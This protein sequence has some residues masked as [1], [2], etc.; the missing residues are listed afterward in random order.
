LAGERLYGS[1]VLGSADSIVI[2]GRS[3]ISSQAAGDNVGLVRVTPRDN[4]LIDNGYISTSTVDIGRAGDISVDAGRLTLINGGQIA[5]SSL[6]SAHGGVGN[7][8]LTRPDSIVTISGTSPDNVSPVPSPYTLSDPNSGI[9]TVTEGTGVGGNIFV[10]VRQ[11][12]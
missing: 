9:F 10:N 4:V 12:E 7:I 5:S 8:H 11:L 6:P 1:D 3:G 2:T